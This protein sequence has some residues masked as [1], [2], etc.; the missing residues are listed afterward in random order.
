MLDDVVAE[1]DRLEKTSGN[2]RDSENLRLPYWA[3]LWDS[4]L[5]MSQ[6]LIRRF[7]RIDS[8][9]SSAKPIFCDALDLGCGQ[10]FTG[11]IAASL[12]CNVLFADLESHALLFAKL[13]SLR[14]TQSARTKQLNWQTTRLDEKFDLIIGADILYER[15]QWDFLEP[16]WQ[17]HLKPDGHILLGE[18]SRHT[19]DNFPQWIQERGWKLQIHEEPVATHVKPIRLFEL[20]R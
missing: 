3:E 12:G 20:T 7:A 18:P 11:M 13:N 10:G 19:G 14:Y 17:H 1:V 4:A 6:V 5:G 15:K 16:F 2:R 9:A 8:L